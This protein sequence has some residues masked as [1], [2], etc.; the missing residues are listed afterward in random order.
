M[1]PCVYEPDVIIPGAASIRQHVVLNDKRHIITKDTDDNVAMWDVLKGK[2]V[3]DHGKRPMEEVIKDNFKK[4]FVPSW[5]TVD[6][7]SGMLQITLDESDFFSA[8]VSAKDAGFFDSTSE[9][10]INYGGMLLRALFEHWS[11]SFSD[12]DED[13]PTHRFNSVPDHTPLILWYAKIYAN[14]PHF[15]EKLL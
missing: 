3:S 6:L 2:K 5:F 12:I 7:K 4:V 10:K 13:S 8:W 9:T 11:R 1:V 14:L 15:K